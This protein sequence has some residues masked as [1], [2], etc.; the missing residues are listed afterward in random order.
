MKEAKKRALY[1]TRESSVLRMKMLKNDP[2][3]KK[4]AWNFLAEKTPGILTFYFDFSK[5][6]FPLMMENFFKKKL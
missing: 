3:S 5:K 2:C 1:L 6:V 4:S